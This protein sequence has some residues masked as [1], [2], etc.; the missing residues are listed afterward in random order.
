[1]THRRTFVRTAALV[2]L[3]VAS[4][5][6]PAAELPV[7]V[8]ISTG[9]E[10]LTG[11]QKD[12]L[13]KGMLLL[14]HVEGQTF[15]LRVHYAGGDTAR[16][17]ALLKQSVAERP[18]VIVVVGLI[19]ARDA[20]D[21]TSTIPVVVATGS[22]LVDGEVVKSYARPGGNITGVSDLTD[23]A[24]AK[25]LELLKS[26]LPNASK[27]ALLVNTQF[28][29]TPKVE[30]RVGATARTLGITVVRVP[31]RDRDSMLLA[32]DSL[33]KTRPD[34]IL[35]AGDP[36]ATTF[37]ANLIE[38]TLS[39]RLPLVH[40]WPGSAE[41]GALLSYQADIEDN[42]RRAAGYV[43]RI[44]K[45]AK[46]AD[47]PIHQPTRYELVVNAKVAQT[48]GITLPSSFLLRADRVIQ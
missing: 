7:V 24:A 47:L 37:R 10:T 25:R 4:R 16:Y 34:A 32:V 38:H 45:G 9:N 44:L 14:G 13:L 15:R 29:N 35:A 17:P 1:V 26:A 21:A 43:D 41:A 33:A 48:L 36:I 46:P 27:V 28:P 31:M 18:A 20:R 23:E 3:G 2:L 42:F 6:Q 5:A 19:A 8:L 12:Y 40:Y 11:W 30:A 39:L 22:D